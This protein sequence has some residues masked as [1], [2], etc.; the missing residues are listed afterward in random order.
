MSPTEAAQYYDDDRRLRFSN[1]LNNYCGFG[2]Y[3]EWKHGER[4]FCEHNRAFCA[5]C[6]ATW[7]RYDVPEGHSM[8]PDV[9]CEQPVSPQLQETLNV[10][11]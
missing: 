1:M 2:C 3:M 5:T 8:D 7:I 11:R 9:V 4:L 6:G 10:Y